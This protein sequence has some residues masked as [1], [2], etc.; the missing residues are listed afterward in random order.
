MWEVCEAA[1]ASGGCEIHAIVRP[2]YFNVHASAA[3]SGM[4]AR[5]VESHLTAEHEV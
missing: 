2:A 5:L 1:A 4:R 3:E